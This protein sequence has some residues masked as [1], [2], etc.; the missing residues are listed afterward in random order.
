MA[1][2]HITNL[3]QTRTFR[4][5]ACLFICDHLGENPWISLCSSCDHDSVTSCLFHQ[6]FC[7]LRTC[8]ISISNYRNRD[9]LFHLTDDIPICLSAVIL[10][11]CPSVHGY[12]C[13]PGLLDDLRDLNR[14]NA[15]VIKSF[16]YLHSDRLINRL[17]HCTDNLINELRILHKCRAFSVTYNLRHRTS[18]VNI[19]DIKRALFHTFCHLTHNLR[20]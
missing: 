16:S 2:H 7:F 17:H 8:H 6:L 10:F 12:S 9:R 14:I 5:H 13:C 20:I 11:S 15:A 4:Q 1:E 19:H 18:H 3:F